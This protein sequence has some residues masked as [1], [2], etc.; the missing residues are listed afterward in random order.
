MNDQCKKFKGYDKEIMIFLYRDVG[1]LWEKNISKN[2]AYAS[3]KKNEKLKQF[4]IKN[5]VI[6]YYH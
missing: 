3:T 2:E 5:K 1:M 6:K 4:F